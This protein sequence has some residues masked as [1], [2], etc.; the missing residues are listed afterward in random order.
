VL[1]CQLQ[2]HQCLTLRCHPRTETYICGPTVWKSLC[3]AAGKYEVRAGN[4]GSM[5]QDVAVCGRMRQYVA[6]CVSVTSVPTVSQYRRPQQHD[7]I[8]L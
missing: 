3:H 5:W 1:A 2:F 8:N 7:V 4:G 6:G